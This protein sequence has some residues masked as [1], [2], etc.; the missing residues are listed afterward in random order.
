MDLNYREK[1]LKAKE[2][3]CVVCGVREDIEVHHKNADKNDNRLENLVPICK[4]HHQR[5]HAGSLD[6]PLTE[7]L[8]DAGELDPRNTV[9]FGGR[10]AV[11]QS[12]RKQV[13]VRIPLRMKAELEQEADK[14]GISRSEYIRTTLEERHEADRLRER[15]EVREKRIDE[16][17]TQ[18][19]KRSQVEEKVD[20]LQTRVEERQHTQD[21]PFFVRWARWWRSRGDAAETSPEGQKV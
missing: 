20:T 8:V 4:S 3:E 15:L 5:L 7:A 10:D 17:E 12:D 18:L 21:A 19:A 9:Y 2:W 14:R 16:L 13:S 1:V 11:K 6:H